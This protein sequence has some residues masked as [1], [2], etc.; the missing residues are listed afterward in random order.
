MLAK[1]D[2]VLMNSN[3]KFSILA[4]K[5]HVDVPLIKLAKKGNPMQYWYRLVW[6][7]GCNK[8][9]RQILSFNF[10]RRIH[11]LGCQ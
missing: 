6:A 11:C 8:L 5:S 3:E 2:I 7:S 1:L 10:L 9:R 4:R